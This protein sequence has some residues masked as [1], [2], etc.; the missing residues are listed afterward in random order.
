MSRII[1][2]A[3]AGELYCKDTKQKFGINYYTFSG[4]SSSMIDRLKHGGPEAKKQGRAGLVEV[5]PAF[6]NV[7]VKLLKALLAGETFPGSGVKTKSV[8]NEQPG[9][10][11]EGWKRSYPEIFA[12]K[13]AEVASSE[14]KPMT[15]AQVKAVEKASKKALAEAKKAEAS[16]DAFDE[17]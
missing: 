14:D 11:L 17:I 10:I 8:W 2:F 16:S 12:V 4:E 15:P 3:V 5:N 1:L 13:K 7:D 6:D 9:H